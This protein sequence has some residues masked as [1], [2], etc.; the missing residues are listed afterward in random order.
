MV[1]FAIDNKGPEGQRQYWRCDYLE[2]Y[3]VKNHTVYYSE[4]TGEYYCNLDNGYRLLDAEDNLS[5]K[6]AKKNV[7]KDLE[8]MLIPNPIK[9]PKYKGNR[10]NLPWDFQMSKE[11][12][13]EEMKKL[14][15]ELA[16]TVENSRIVDVHGAEADDVAGV[17][18]NTSNQVNH[19]LYTHDG[20]WTQLQSE[21]THILNLSTD[22][23]LSPIDTTEFIETK[24]IQGD[25]GD[26]I[27]STWI[28]GKATDI[29]G[30]DCNLGAKGA[31]TIWANK[32]T[33][34]IE[35]NVYGRNRMLIE[36]SLD[37]IPKDI[38]EGTIKAIKEKVE[39]PKYE[40]SHFTLS[41]KEQELLLEERTSSILTRKKTP[42]LLQELEGDC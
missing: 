13:R 27:S 26:G 30:K 1:V 36:L 35:D 40:W 38:I 15:H 10:A 20:D 23:Y 19:V 28:E 14:L 31:S 12:Y 21:T 42:V 25:S 3:Y 8:V 18:A 11:L 6:L 4:S 7:P 33:H 22:T 17:L 5:K 24:I 34:L 9:F 29:R 16:G 32:E 2:D 37:T 41:P 39:Y